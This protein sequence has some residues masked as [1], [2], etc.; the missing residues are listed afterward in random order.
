V[1]GETVLLFMNG[2]GT[3]TPAVP[4][5]AV[6]PSNPLSDSDEFDAGELAVLL[7][8]AAGNAGL[9]DIQFAGL[10]PCCAGLY[11]VNFTLPGARTVSSGDATILF[12]T[13][14][15]QTAMATIALS[16]GFRGAAVPGAAGL[17]PTGRML[18]KL[19]KAPPRPRGMKTRRRAL[20]DR[21]I[22]Q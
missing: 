18:A 19:A 11:Q 10:A 8:D 4:N 15:A 3:V 9:G 6:G 2:L 12:E 7:V 14:E 13:L 5:G 20:P 21:V 22:V 17:K 1:P 16:S